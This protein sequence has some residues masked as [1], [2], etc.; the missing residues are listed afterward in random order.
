MRDEKKSE[1]LEVRL[2]YS[3]KIAFM[4]ACRKEGITA[5]EALRAGIAQ[6]LATRDGQSQRNNLIEDLVTAMKM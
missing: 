4:E 3:Q 1:T 6:F 2:P 5:S